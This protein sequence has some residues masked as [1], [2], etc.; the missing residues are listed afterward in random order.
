MVLAELYITF[1]VLAFLLFV[2]GIE[3]EKK[4]I[5][6]P[7]IA[8]VMFFTLMVASNDIDSIFSGVT[9]ESQIG[10]YFNLLLGFMSFMLFI[11]VALDH[12]RTASENRKPGEEI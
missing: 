3:A 6:Y 1:E 9:I 4:Q 10:F 11:F 12:F 5:I 8:M 2:K 7:V